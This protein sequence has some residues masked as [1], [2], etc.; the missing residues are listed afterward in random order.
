M[1]YGTVLYAVSPLK[2]PMIPDHEHVQYTIKSADKVSTLILNVEHGTIRGR[3]SYS[4]STTSDSQDM[5]L[6]I[7][8]D[9]L[10]PLK[11]LRLQKDGRSDFMTTSELGTIPVLHDDEILIVDFNDL[12]HVL[13]GYPFDHPRTLEIVFPY[14]ADRDEKRKMSFM[15]KYVKSETIN[16]QGGSYDSYKLQLAAQ[17][18][19]GMSVFSGM[20]PKTYFWY[21]QEA[22][23]TL[24]RYEG[25]TGPG[26]DEEIIM[27]MVHYRIDG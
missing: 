19:G 1:F 17:L 4:I 3:Q 27:E 7:L 23:H 2:D 15:I 14:Q 20:I 18:S 10:L 16:L 25:G 21:S 22:P 9:G 24:L 6:E 26:G 11:N 12:S 8:R 5:S 13:R